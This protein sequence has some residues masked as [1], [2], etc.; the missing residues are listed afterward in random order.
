MGVGMN[1]EK[2]RIEERLGFY[3]YIYI[4][5]RPFLSC[6]NLVMKARLVHSFYYENSFFIHEQAK[7]I[8]I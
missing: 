3:L 5:N 8:F 1:G 7:Q 2:R 6:L 4:C